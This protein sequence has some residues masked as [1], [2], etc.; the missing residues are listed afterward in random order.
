MLINLVM[1]MILA[2]APATKQ[3]TGEEEWQD[4]KDALMRD[5]E[6]DDDDTM[7]MEDQDEDE[8]VIIMDE[9][10]SSYPDDAEI[11]EEQSKQKKQ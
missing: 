7:I 1:L 8:D 9:D 2:A 11:K 3:D 10:N 4:Q 6:P 5:D